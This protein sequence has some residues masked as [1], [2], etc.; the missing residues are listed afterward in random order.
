M[1]GTKLDDII[2]IKS[3]M[4]VTILSNTEALCVSDGRV[5]TENNKGREERSMQVG[6]AKWRAMV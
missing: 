2:N 3:G 5:S 6:A 1:G 4:G